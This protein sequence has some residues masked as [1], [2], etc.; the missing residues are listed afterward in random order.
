MAMGRSG[1]GWRWVLAVLGLLLAAEPAVAQLRVTI[2]LPRRLY[3]LYEPVIATVTIRNLSGRDIVLRDTESNNWFGFEL[4]RQDGSPVAPQSTKYSL[5]PLE[6]AA[7]DTVRR[8]INLTPLYAMQE[9]GTYRIRAVIYFEELDRWYVSNYEHID[10]TEGKLIW[11]QEAGVPEDGGIREVELRSFRLPEGNRLY[12][13]ISDPESGVVYC[14]MK[15]GRLLSHD[16]PQVVFGRENHLH[17]LHPAAPRTYM[18]TRMTLNGEI[19]ERETYLAPKYNPK[20][21]VNADRVVFVRGG[22]PEAPEMPPGLEPDPAPRLSE[23]PPGMPGRG[24]DE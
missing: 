22:V 1:R 2:E 11:R 21:V 7:G 20:L 15:L 6:F 4:Q 16:N 14:N 5:E 10:I 19:I 17:I 18:H 24:G 23:R 12:V 13:R 8:N 9:F 3:M